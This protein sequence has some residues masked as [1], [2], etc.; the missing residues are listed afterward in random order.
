M[1]EKE[2]T[3]EYTGEFT[4]KAG[5]AI[6]SFSSATKG[7]LGAI[8]YKEGKPMILTNEHVVITDD[9]EEEKRNKKLLID[10]V[11]DRGW[12]LPDDILRRIEKGDIPVFHP[13]YNGG[14]KEAKIIAFVT[15]TD[16][17]FD[18]ALCE[19]VVPLENISREIL[20]ETLGEPIPPEEDSNI[21]KVG[22]ITD[23]TAGNVHQVSGKNILVK[24]IGK[25]TVSE[26]GDSGA[27][28]IKSGTNSPI[29]LLHKGDDDYT[30]AN[31]LVSIQAKMGFTFRKPR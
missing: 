25:S 28:F 10:R 31:A 3:H 17:E 30:Y 5:I 29:G 21:Y 22:C 7:T 13:P 16:T 15:E 8:V 19:I 20:G 18:A 1:Q 27:V 23:T 2:K 14:E 4:L 12:S 24:K 11:K 9:P 6:S 26:P